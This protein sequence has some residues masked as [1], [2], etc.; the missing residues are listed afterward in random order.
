[1]LVLPYF[2]VD[3]LSVWSGEILVNIDADDDF[4]YKISYNGLVLGLFLKIMFEE[5]SLF[6]CNFSEAY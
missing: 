5:D 4:M 1:M 2:K 3:A 6:V